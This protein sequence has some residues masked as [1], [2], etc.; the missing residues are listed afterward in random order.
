MLLEFNI[1]LTGYKFD[2]LT[3]M[4]REENDKR[5]HV[6]WLCKCDCNNETIVNNSV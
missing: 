1:D 3:V 4:K 5:S 6:C 2:R